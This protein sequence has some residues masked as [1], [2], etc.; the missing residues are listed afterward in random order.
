MADYKEQLQSNNNELSAILETVEGL[1][2]AP[3]FQEKTVMP[4]STNQEIIADSGY[5]GLSKVIVTG[6]ANLMSENIAKGASIF[7]VEGNYSGTGIE[8]CNIS[9][10]G[11]SGAEK[12]YVSY[13]ETLGIYNTNETSTSCEACVKGS[14]ILCKGMG[15]YY[16]DEPS[17]DG[18]FSV[19]YTTTNDRILFINANAANEFSIFWNAD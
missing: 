12:C 6:D 18:N 8:T 7:G 14:F 17:S 4:S 2:E 9:M 3:T 15:S 1:P 19:L 11:S 13:N 16:Y 10:F 5:D